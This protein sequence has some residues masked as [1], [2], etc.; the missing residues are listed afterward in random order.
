MLSGV[1][2]R[3]LLI[4]NSS[5][6]SRNWVDIGMYAACSVDN[7]KSGVGGKYSTPSEQLAV[8]ILES[9]APS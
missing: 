7:L 9:L 2:R 4:G 6:K 3:S 5:M 8:N 1:N